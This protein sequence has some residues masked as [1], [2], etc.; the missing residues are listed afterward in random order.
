TPFNPHGSAPQELVFMVE[1]G[2]APLEA[3]RAATANGA[4]LL[5]LPDVGT[6]EAGKR[7]DLVLLDGDP[8]ED[9]RTVLGR[10]RVWQ[11]GRPV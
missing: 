10:K 9:P 1:W 6:I 4:E 2:M 3:L 7:A 8:S 11:A 5:R